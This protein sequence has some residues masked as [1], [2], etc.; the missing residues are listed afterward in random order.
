L[1]LTEGK[2][3]EA[4]EELHNLYSSPNIVKAIKSRRMRWVGYIACMRDMRNVYKI[5]V[6]NL[7]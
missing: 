4:G 5:L 2:W 6:A 3:W 7:K 1:D